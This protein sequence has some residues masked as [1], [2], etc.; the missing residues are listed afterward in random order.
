MKGW[1]TSQL[2]GDGFGVIVRAVESR[3]A[4]NGA[5]EA[6]NAER[7]NGSD[8]EENPAPQPAQSAATEF[9]RPNE[10]KNL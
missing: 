9:A 3:D 4:E 2:V 10:I 6:D 8:G 7:S 5:S 1:L